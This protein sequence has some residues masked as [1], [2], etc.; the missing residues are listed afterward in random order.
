MK[1]IIAGSRSFDDYWF[2]EQAVESFIMSY[3]YPLEDVEIVSGGATGADKLGEK[4]ATKNN[5][6]LT[7]MLPDY[8]QYNPKSAPIMRN[9]RMAKYATHCIVFWDGVS[10]GTRNMINEAKKQG[11]ELRVIQPPPTPPIK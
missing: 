6:K 3:G 5:L 1:L 11:L 2:L 7:K 8:V 9:K 4:Y 10:S